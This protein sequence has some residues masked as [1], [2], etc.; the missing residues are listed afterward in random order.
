MPCPQP[1]TAGAHIV[2]FPD[3]L[4]WVQDKYPL[5]NCGIQTACTKLCNVHGPEILPCSICFSHPTLMFPLNERKMHHCHKFLDPQLLITNKTR[6]ALFCHHSRVYS[7][8]SASQYLS[9]LS[10][11]QSV[12]VMKQRCI[13]KKEGW[14]VSTSLTAMSCLSKQLHYKGQEKY[15][16][17]ANKVFPS[18][19]CTLFHAFTR[20][21]C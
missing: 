2:S 20:D 3:T 5:W 9:S 14:S 15:S 16:T 7:F 6:W 21:S 4:F 17:K 8:V 10:I 11:N 12:K 13:M 18:V 19:L 1:H